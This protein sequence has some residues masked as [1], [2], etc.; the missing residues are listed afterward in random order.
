MINRMDN[1]SMRRRKQIIDAWRQVAPDATLNGMTL[2][3]FTEATNEPEAVRQRIADANVMLE[4]LRQQRLMAE[5]QLR[6]QIAELV[7]AV[8]ASKEHGENSPLYRAFGYVP[9]NARKSGLSRR[10]ATTTTEGAN[11]A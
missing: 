5:G 11:A 9:K 4:A 6:E 3:Q 10:S 2:E 1:R 7:N 8:K